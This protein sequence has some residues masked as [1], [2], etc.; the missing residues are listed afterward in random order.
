MAGHKIFVSYKYWDS[1]VQ[2]LPGY[3]K[4]IC[5]DYVTEFERLV[6]GTDDIFNGEHDGEDLSGL[7]EETIW[8]HLRNRIYDSS[9]TIVFIS[10]NM[11]DKDVPDYDQW[12]PWEISYSL[13]EYQRKTKTG[14]SVTSRTNAMLAVILPDSCGRYDYFYEQLACCASSCIRLHTERLFTIHRENMFNRTS[15]QKRECG[16]TGD[17]VWL[18][19]PSYI[20]AVRWREFIANYRYHVEQAIARQTQI[21]EYK[22]VKRAGLERM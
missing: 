20:E 8:Y 16:T 11:R 15:G 12:I 19:E 4:T 2:S 17:T 21:A 7:N 10:P 5:R 18:G 22:I 9:V 3:G 6:A 13:S 1:D 14:K